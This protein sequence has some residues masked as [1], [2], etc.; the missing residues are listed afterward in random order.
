M[1]G[2]LVRSLV[3]EY[4]TCRGA[5]MIVCNNYWAHALGA[6]LCNKR[7]LQWETHTPQLER[8]PFSPELE[9]ARAP[10]WRPSATNNNENK[11]NLKIKKKKAGGREWSKEGEGERK[12]DSAHLVYDAFFILCSC[13][14][15]PTPWVWMNFLLRFCLYSYHESYLISWEKKGK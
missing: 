9:K 5:S 14:D 4:P 1:Q 10:Q 2:T 13:D 8:S 6:T 11:I 7:P 12:R 15:C 3:Q